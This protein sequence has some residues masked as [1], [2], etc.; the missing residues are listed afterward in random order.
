[1]Q[2][3]VPYINIKLT[4]IEFLIS[5]PLKHIQA[6]MSQST[7]KFNAFLFFK[8]PSAW[9]SGVR[10]KELSDQHAVATVKYRWANQNPFKS[11]SSPKVT[12]H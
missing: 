1:M 6:L 8:L 5:I 7:G 4:N 10:L 3:I 9:W 2:N 11:N 12:T